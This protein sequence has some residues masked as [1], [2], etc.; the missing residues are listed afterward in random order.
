MSTTPER[1]RLQEELRVACEG[2]DQ[3]L[4]ALFDAARI[5]GLPVFLREIGAKFASLYRGTPA[6]ELAHVAPYLARLPLTSLIIPWLLVDPAP[7]EAGMF[8]VAGTDAD[9]LRHHL[10]RYLIILDAKGGENFFR[11]YDPRV[12]APFLDASTPEET[13]CF[14]GPI[15]RLLV[16]ASVPPVKAPLF[17]S[18]TAP[19]VPRVPAPP[20]ASN[21][22]RLRPEHEERFARETWA[23]YE[24]R[25]LLYLKAHYS[26]PLRGKTDEDVRRI[27][28]NAKQVG[29]G[30]GITAGR[31]V[32][33]LAE[34]LVL[35][36]EF[37]ARKHIE[38]N[39]SRQRTLA[40][41][42]LRDYLRQK[43]SESSTAEARI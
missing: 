32:T 43:Q 3:R 37:A 7:A 26:V 27:I 9:A 30:L 28:A 15:R 25:C 4:Y 36:P 23:F 33:T 22:F 39:A 19:A 24:Q 38:A 10:R 12:I 35:D 16:C 14:F 41:T 17:R 34:V 20:N 13:A 6:T 31:D 8:L 1:Q 5:R 11:F 18:W 2:D 42:K 21:K 40:L 29:G